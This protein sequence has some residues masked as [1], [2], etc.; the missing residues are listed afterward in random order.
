MFATGFRICGIKIFPV[1]NMLPALILA[2][3]ISSLWVHFF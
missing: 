1:A 3:P 2:M